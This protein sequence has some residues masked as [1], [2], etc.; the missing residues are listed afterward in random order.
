M[1][2]TVGSNVLEFLSSRMTLAMAT[3][4]ENGAPNASYA[5]FVK[6]TPWLYVSTSTFEA[7][8]KPDR[9]DKSESH[10]HR[11]RDSAAL[12]RLARG[13]LITDQ[14]G[15]YPFRVVRVAREASGSLQLCRM[16]PI[17]DV[18]ND[19]C[20]SPPEKQGWCRMAGWLRR[21]RPDHQTSTCR[22]NTDCLQS[23][24]ARRMRPRELSR[25]SD[26]LVRIFNHCTP[27]LAIRQS[28]FVGVR[29]NWRDVKPIQHS[30]SLCG[31]RN[32][33]LR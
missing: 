4:D 31:P 22:Q 26:M 5:P 19:V 8:T 25:S 11:P 27:R 30:V 3:V 12:S 17:D 2:N 29:A 21:R 33:R 28:P 16:G 24:G 6:R 32:S 7:H 18:L 15:H 10:V 23:H 1:A 20:L 9:N 13:P 14:F